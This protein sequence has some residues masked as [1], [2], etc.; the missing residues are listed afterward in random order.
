MGNFLH[1]FVS[2][3]EHSDITAVEQSLAI[4]F[5]EDLV[6]FWNKHQGGWPENDIF[7]YTDMYG[8]ANDGQVMSFFL[9]NEREGEMVHKTL[10]F[11]KEER[12]LEC[13]AIIADEAGGH[14]ILYNSDDG[15][16]YVWDHENEDVMPKNCYPIGNNFTHFFNDVLHKPEMED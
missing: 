3:A 5:P 7:D 12:I 13:H 4:K 9:L 11:R 1:D 10:L 14:K 8:V 15:K 6:A 2:G 16:I